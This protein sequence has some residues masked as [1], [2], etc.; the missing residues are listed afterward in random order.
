M[1]IHRRLEERLA[2]FEGTR[3]RAAV[4]LGLPRQPRRDRRAAGRGDAV[5]SDELNHASIV[6]GCRLSRAEVVVYRHR[7][8]EHLE[9]SLRASGGRAPAR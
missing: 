3:G 7:D 6:D 2:E 5:F 8:V 4:R 9:W 1:T